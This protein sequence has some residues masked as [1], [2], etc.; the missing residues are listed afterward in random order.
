MEKIIRL[1]NIFWEV[2]KF[3]AVLQCAKYKSQSNNT[4]RISLVFLDATDN[5]A[6]AEV[7]VRDRMWE[8]PTNES[9]QNVP[10]LLVGL[11]Q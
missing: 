8:N 10:G 5:D 6:E 2:C 4:F 11:K 7:I 9:E 1:S 3:F